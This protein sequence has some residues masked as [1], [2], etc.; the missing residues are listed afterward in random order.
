MFLVFRGS[1]AMIL[2]M[3]GL[4]AVY[5][6]FVLGSGAIGF[7]LS[8][9]HA[10]GP[11]PAWA[12]YVGL[13]DGRW[14]AVQRA[15]AQLSAGIDGMQR[16]ARGLRRGRAAGVARARRA[17]ARVLPVIVYSLG[18]QAP[19]A[20]LILWPIAL[21][22]GGVVAPVPAGGGAIEFAFK[23][24]LGGAIPAQIFGAALVWW[25][26]YTFYIFVILGAF[27]AGGT[28][29]RALRSDGS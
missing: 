4:V 22:Y 15:L 27:A 28:V 1:G 26:F 9:R 13:K 20:P 5:A 29:L 2:G 12:K 10:A 19:L 18:A 6:L 21:T 16:C 14:L 8:K 3:V 23:A 7:A 17:A 24:T 25:R 11:A